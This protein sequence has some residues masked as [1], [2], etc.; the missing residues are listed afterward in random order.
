MACGGA[1]SR[2]I[3]CREGHERT[4]GAT[5]RA[6]ADAVPDRRGLGRDGRHGIPGREVAFA[7]QY[8]RTEPHDVRTLKRLGR[9]ASGSPLV[10]LVQAKDAAPEDELR[11]GL[12][13]LV[14]L[15]ALART[16]ADSPTGH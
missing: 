7:G 11:L 15:A 9:A 5:G 8:Q 14:A 10:D 3:F 6:P 1:R 13:A 4:R 2:P 16:D 12:I